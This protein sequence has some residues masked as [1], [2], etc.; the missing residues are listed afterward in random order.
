[1]PLRRI[2]RAHEICEVGIEKDPSAA[3]LRAGY[4]ALF[5]SRT[6]F[7][8]MHTQELRRFLEVKRPQELEGPASE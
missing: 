7:F 6:N 4:A 8:G 1:L 3:R 5:R 2:Q